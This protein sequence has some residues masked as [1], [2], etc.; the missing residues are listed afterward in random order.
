MSICARR[1]EIW[2]AMEVLRQQGKIL[3]VGSSNH[4]GWHI[5]K[6]QEAAQRRNFMGLV[7]E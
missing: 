4:G 3:Y 5:A 2:E 1:D 7:L 6:G